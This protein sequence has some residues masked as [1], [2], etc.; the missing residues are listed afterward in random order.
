MRAGGLYYC[1]WEQVMQ[2]VTIVIISTV[3]LFNVMLN[4]SNLINI[5][6]YG[7]ADLSTCRLWNA[8]K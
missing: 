8:F 6:K 7:A 5:V 3:W 2:E 4:M 1:S